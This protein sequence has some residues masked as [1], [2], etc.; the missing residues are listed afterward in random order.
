MGYVQTKEDK[1]VLIEAV[2][3]IVGKDKLGIIL[4]NELDEE[5]EIPLALASNLYFYP[6]KYILILFGKPE[7]NYWGDKIPKEL[8]SITLQEYPNCCASAILSGLDW[9]E[10]GVLEDGVRIVKIAEL[11]VK[12]ARYGQV[13]ISDK[14]GGEFARVI[15]ELEGYKEVSSIR[16]VRTN[17]IVKTWVKKL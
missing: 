10:N 11:F 15:P 1:R 9:S 6:S 14:I 5:I 8:T 16:N 4:D 7:L 12:A 13:F 17:S 2:R 3:E